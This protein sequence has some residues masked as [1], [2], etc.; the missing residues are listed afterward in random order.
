M[1]SD[2]RYNQS[3]YNIKNPEKYIGNNLPKCRSS[4]ERKYCEYL[5]TNPNVVK[6]SSE[7]IVIHYLD[8]ITQK[9]KRYFVD[10][11]I[12]TSQGKKFLIE[13]KPHREILVPRKTKEKK[14]STILYEQKTFLRNTAKWN[15][16]RAFCQKYG[17]EFRIITE[18]EFKFK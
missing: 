15:A 8:P 12:L 16:A 10:F 6:W 3:F 14:P 1:H 5:D 7:T 4:W 13:V 9:E 18:K 17:W 2:Q 11:F